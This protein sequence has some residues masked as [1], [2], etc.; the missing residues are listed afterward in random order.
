MTNT[1]IRR[2]LHTATALS[3]ALGLT[4]TAE[5]GVHFAQAA[6]T[7]M[8]TLVMETAKH[9]AAGNLV[10]EPAPFIQAYEKAYAAEHMALG[11]M[12]IVLG[13]FFHALLRA[14]DERPVHITVKPGKKKRKQIAWYWMEV[15]V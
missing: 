2:F 7:G 4:M 5:H 8:G 14:R 12:L 6:A 11:I 1:H 3:L 9:A 13:F 10:I 15:R